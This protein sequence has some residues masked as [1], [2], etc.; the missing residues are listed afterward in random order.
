MPRVPLSG[1]ARW[2]RVGVVTL[3]VVAVCAGCRLDVGVAI[4]MQPDGSGTVAVTATADPELVTAA[5]SAFA[6]LRLDD[7]KQAGWTVSGPAKGADGSMAMTLTKPFATPAEANTILA[8]LN[9]PAGPLVGLTVGLERSF[10]V[11]ASTLAGHTQLTGGLAAFSDAALA[12]ALGSVPLAN[13]VTQPVDQVLGLS[14]TAHFPGQVVSADGQIAADRQS[15][16][17]HPS[18][19]DGAVTPINARF[20]LVDQG[21]RDARRTSHLAWGALVLY[22]GALLVVVV[23]V[24]V[25]VRRRRRPPS[26][27]P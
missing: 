21:A 27:S 5:P 7:V 1:R 2:W 13:L 6:D 23:L 14:V 25:V 22:L 26:S 3:A 8:E 19:A 17:W 24:T 4:T 10:A 12:Q 20:E 15:V 11:V 18:L 9:G 16:M